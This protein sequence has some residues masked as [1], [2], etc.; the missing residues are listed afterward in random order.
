MALQ[1]SKQTNKQVTDETILVVKRDDIFA[2]NEPFH[3]LQKEPLEKVMEAIQTKKQ[4]LPRSLMDQD[5][6]YKQIIIYLIFNY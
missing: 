5:H 6:A 2:N 1:K 4:F 3:G